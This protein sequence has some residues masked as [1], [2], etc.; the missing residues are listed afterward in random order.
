MWAMLIC[1]DVFS[2]IT[3][4]YVT[5][6]NIH[7]AMHVNSLKLQNTIL[8][9]GTQGCSWLRHYATRQKVA[10]SIPDGVTGIFR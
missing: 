5:V 6:H 7:I 2:S 9:W 4:S 1:S 10:D 8:Q 3:Y